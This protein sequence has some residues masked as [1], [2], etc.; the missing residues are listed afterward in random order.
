MKHYF[1]DMHIHIGA[2]S[3]G[4]PVKITASKSLVFES[5]VKESLS[6]KGM[7]MIGVVDRASPGVLR[8]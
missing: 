4:R 8:V 2:T 7:D 5:I 3:E 1:S 6:R